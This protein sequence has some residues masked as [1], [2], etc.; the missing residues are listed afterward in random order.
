MELSCALFQNLC[1]YFCIYQCLW[2]YMENKKF[3][4]FWFCRANS[5]RLQKYIT[6]PPDPPSDQFYFG[7]SARSRLCFVLWSRALCRNLWN[8]ISCMYR[9]FYF[10][11]V[12]TCTA[13]AHTYFFRNL[14]VLQFGDCDRSAGTMFLLTYQ[15]DRDCSFSWAD[16]SHQFYSFYSKS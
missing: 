15:E 3:L 7:F 9:I 2:N 11:Y 5:E 14:L 12:G 6:F 4:S 13:F 16:R 1:M 8:F 10:R